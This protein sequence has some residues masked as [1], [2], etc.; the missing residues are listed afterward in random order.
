MPFQ[1]NDEVVYPGF[2]VGRIIGLVR[3]AWSDAQAQPYY[4]IVGERSTVWVAVNDAQAR[5][6]RRL[7]TR[8]ELAHFRAVLCGQ[9]E[10][11]DPDFRQRRLGLRSHL[12][13]GTLQSLCEVVRDLSGRAWAKPLNEADAG[14]LRETRATLLQ[15]WAAADGI[16]VAQASSQVDG[17]LLDGRKAQGA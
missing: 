15:E 13:Q 14:V 4:E 17:L 5:G 2:G 7:T 10:R 11:L 9:P 16:S 1:I 6:M 12:R 3:Q 8:D